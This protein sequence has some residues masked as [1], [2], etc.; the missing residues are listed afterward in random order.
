[1]N[2]DNNSIEKYSRQ[3]LFKAIGKEGQRRLR[4][5]YAVIAGCGALGSV[6]ANSL[7]RAGVGRIKIIDRDFIE[8]S[9]LQRQTLFDEED[10]RNDLPK[11]VAAQKRL[12]KINSEVEID[13][14]VSDIDQTNVEGLIKGADIVLDGLDNFETRFI[15]NDCCLKNNIPWI[16][17]ACVGSSGLSMNI[18]PNMTPCLRCVFESPPPPGVSPTC[19]TAGIIAPIAGAIASIQVTEALK[20]LTDNWSYINKKLVRIDIWNGKYDQIHIENAKEISNCPACKG[21]RYEF[22]TARTGMS[23]TTLCGRNAIQIKYRDANKIDFKDLS[24]R[25]NTVGETRHN[26]FM[27]KFK[28][29]GYELTLFNDG[30][31]I[32]FGT[33]DP[34]K[35]RNL[36][37]RYI[38]I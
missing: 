14:V 20:I 13:A 34:V 30:R 29:G 12:Q 23:I 37:A 8:E 31:L 4:Q 22:L 21:G 26:D 9:N 25:L 32:I 7:T 19:D 10:I 33:D 5:K 6:I 36:Y 17:G 24:K 15:I 16:Y 28:A 1:M 18:I 35:A 3:I 27:M 2:R 11:A 38:G